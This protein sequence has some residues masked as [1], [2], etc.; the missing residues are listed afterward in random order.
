MPLAQLE[1]QDKIVQC[2]SPDTWHSQVVLSLCGTEEE[3]ALLL[4]TQEGLSS[5]LQEAGVDTTAK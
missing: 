2:L 3:A 4:S 5:Q 1:L